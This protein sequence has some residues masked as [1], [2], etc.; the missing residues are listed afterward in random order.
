MKYLTLR[1]LVLKSGSNFCDIEGKVLLIFI[2]REVD[3][4]K[5]PVG[6]FCC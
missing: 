4:I 2:F 3:C 1:F 6:L 5:N